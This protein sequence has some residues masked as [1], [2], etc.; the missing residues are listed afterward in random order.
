MEKFNIRTLCPATNTVK[1]K[2]TFSWTSIKNYK[3][4]CA[5]IHSLL[6]IRDRMINTT[7]LQRLYNPIDSFCLFT[8]VYTQYDVSGQPEGV[9][10]KPQMPKTPQLTACFTRL[11]FVPKSESKSS[12]QEPIFS[13]S[14]GWAVRLSDSWNTL[15]DKTGDKL[16]EATTC[17]REHSSPPCDT[18]KSNSGHHNKG[19]RITYS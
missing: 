5:F 12:L 9:Q 2:D 7:S 6:F 15:S 16:Q 1:F 3:S 19:K 13:G 18:E 11:S 10:K 4:V 8:M 14:A 17:H